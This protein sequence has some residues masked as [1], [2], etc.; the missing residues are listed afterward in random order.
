M[1]TKRHMCATPLLLLFNESIVH[2]WAL[3][4]CGFVVVWLCGSVALW[5]FGFAAL[6]LCGFVDLLLCGFVALWFCG[7]LALWRCGFMVLWRCGCLSL[8]LCAFWLYGS[9]ALWPCCFVAFCIQVLC[10]TKVWNSHVF[11]KSETRRFRET[12][13]LIFQINFRLPLLLLRV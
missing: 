2:F 6:W 5:L 10:L 12:A 9:A 3:W 8:W 1:T 7:F 4:L 13:W 11:S